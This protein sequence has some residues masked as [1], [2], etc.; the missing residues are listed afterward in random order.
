M[1]K[2]IDSVFNDGN[3]PVVLKD[4]DEVN[5]YGFGRDGECITVICVNRKDKPQANRAMISRYNYND[6]ENDVPYYVYLDMMRKIHIEITLSEY[7]AKLT[8]AYNLFNF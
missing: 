6:S 4:K 5:Y 3:F 8:N 7:D 1:E 2:E